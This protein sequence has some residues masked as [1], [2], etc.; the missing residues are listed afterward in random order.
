MPTGLSF[1]EICPSLI[2]FKNIFHFPN[3]VTFSIKLES[4][5]RLIW[6]HAIY[7]KQKAYGN[8]VWASYPVPSRERGTVCGRSTAVGTRFAFPKMRRF[9]ARLVRP[10]DPSF[11]TS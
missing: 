7:F 11:N 6:F 4:V 1:P 9:I 8:D 3:C 5:F 2:E 10:S